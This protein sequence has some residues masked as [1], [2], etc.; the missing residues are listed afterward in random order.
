MKIILLLISIILTIPCHV[1]AIEK[2]VSEDV[3]HRTEKI[4]KELKIKTDKKTRLAPTNIEKSE[5]K[6]PTSVTNDNPEIKKQ[7]SSN[8]IAPARST[9]NSDK[10]TNLRVAKATEWNAYATIA[11]AILTTILAIE[12]VRLRLVQAKQI[13]RLNDEG[14]KPKVELFLESNKYAINFIEIHIVNNG[15]GTANNI[16]FSFESD[17]N[18]AFETSKH[19]ISKIEKIFLFKAGLKYLGASDIEEGAGDC[20]ILTS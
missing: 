2:S 5:E 12:T 11:I 7:T 15:N 9:I 14:I 19:I 20:F 3:L 8:S 13:K 17:I 16:K 1:S 4:T 6:T 18:E 10:K